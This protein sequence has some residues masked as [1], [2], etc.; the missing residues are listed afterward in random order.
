M[1]GQRLNYLRKSRGFTAL[2]LA[3]MLHISLRS[4]RMYESNDRSPSLETLVKLADFYD[5]STDFLLGR[6]QF[7]KSRGVSADGYPIDPPS[8]PTP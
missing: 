4:Y 6:D 8:H 1:I 5:V 3:N 2:E 7:L